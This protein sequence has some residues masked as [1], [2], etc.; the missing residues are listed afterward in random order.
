MSAM[1]DKR[2]LGRLRS[3]VLRLDEAATDLDRARVAAEVRDLAEGVV[4]EAVR[5]ANRGGQTWREIGAEMG[6]P[7]QTLYRRYGGDER[8]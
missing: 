5:D 7:F 6:V 8:K 3:L 4:A 2:A 1:R